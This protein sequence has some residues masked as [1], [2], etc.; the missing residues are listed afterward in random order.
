[1]VS[2]VH[3]EVEVYVLFGY[4]SVTPMSGQFGLGL[5]LGGA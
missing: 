3:S 5:G 4:L 2:L 1:M